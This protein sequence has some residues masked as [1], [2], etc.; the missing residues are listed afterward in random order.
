MPERYIRFGRAYRRLRE[1]QSQADCGKPVSEIRDDTLRQMLFVTSILHER[2][3]TNPQFPRYH[4]AAIKAAVGARA[5]SFDRCVLEDKGFPDAVWKEFEA[6]CEK[7][8]PSHT[9]GRGKSNPSHTKGP[10]EG[11][12]RLLRQHGKPNWVEFLRTMSPE[13]AWEKLDGLGGVGPKLASFVLREFQAFFGVWAEPP[14]HSWHCFMPV[15]RW[16][17]R[18]VKLLWKHEDWPGEP[19]E[20]VKRYQVLAQRIAEEFTSNDAGMNF[21]MG[22]WFLNAMRNQVLAVNGR[23]VVGDL[24]DDALHN[25]AEKLDV[26]KVVAALSNDIS[27]P[28]E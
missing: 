1:L 15:D 21:N 4:R 6:L 14:R 19:P 2:A 12:L 13:Q 5:T 20:A 25:V 10:V 18:V 26:E 7:P 23:I 24:E 8:N 16:V 27:P 22:A 17:L 11:T 9:K 28:T 3:G